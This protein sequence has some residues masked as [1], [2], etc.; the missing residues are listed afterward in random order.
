MVRTLT[1]TLT[2]AVGLVFSLFSPLAVSQIEA[3]QID[4]NEARI[5]I[6]YAGVL[7][8]SLTIRFEQAVGLSAD[9]L[10]V[11][12]R[13]VGLS[14]MAKLQ[15]RFPDPDAITMP[16]AFPLLISINPSAGHGLTFAGI[17]DIELYTT[18]LQYILG[19]PLR[20]FSSSNGELFRDI[21]EEISSGSYRVRGSGGQFS[22]FLIASDLRPLTDVALR[23][24]DRLEQISLTSVDVAAAQSIADLIAN[25]KNNWMNG[26]LSSAI[27]DLREL[28]AFVIE[29]AASGDVPNVWHAGGATRNVAGM[30]RANAKTLRYT[31]GM[32][33]AGLE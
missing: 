14:S 7:D 8:A 10:G 5:D 15:S 19:T 4:G 26:Q 17:V 16:A 13:L 3:V 2:F 22:E 25:A 9:A 6:D 32:M 12:A 18:T 28:D 21:T 1:L 30:L 27:S 11:S 20:L 31:I 33:A 24:F 29:A 23:K